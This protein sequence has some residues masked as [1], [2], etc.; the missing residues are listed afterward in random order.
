MTNSK[1]NLIGVHLSKSEV[2]VIKRISANRQWTKS[3]AAAVLIRIGL[4]HQEWLVEPLVRSTNE[5]TCAHDLRPRGPPAD[6]TALY[7]CLKCGLE[8]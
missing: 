6:P 4:D 2:E 1:E 5:K 7:R 3:K 8:A